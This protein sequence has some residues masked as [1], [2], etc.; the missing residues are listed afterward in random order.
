[1][2]PDIV[3]SYTAKTI[4]DWPEITLNSS[5]Q[6]KLSQATLSLGQ[7]NALLRLRPE[8]Q[9]LINTFKQ[10]EAVASALMD[11]IHLSLQEL[12]CHQMEGHINAHT[13][14]ALEVLCTVDAMT[15][16]LRHIE[17]DK[18][19][20][21]ELIFLLHEELMSSGWGIHKHPGEFRI[22]TILSST[23][24]KEIVALRSPEPENIEQEWEKIKLIL[25]SD[26]HPLIKAGKLLATLEWLQPFQEGNGRIAR[27]MATLTLYESNFLTAPLLLLNSYFKKHQVR[28]FQHL[29]KARNENEF[30]EWILFFL[31]AIEVSAIQSLEIS[32]R[33]L[34]LKD[35]VK[36]DI[37][38]IGRLSFSAKDALESFWKFPISNIETIV[39][40]ANITHATSGKVVDRLEK[41]DV[42]LLREITGQKRNR[43]F[44]YKPFYEILNSEL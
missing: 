15:L 16:G 32:A 22:E 1:M 28:Y 40:D 10:K 13:D 6:N 39:S 2:H 21:D 4:P 25:A 14:D 37:E 36:I 17:R 23:H 18:A 27:L 34:Q 24:A 3:P 30:E 41:K 44:L 42:D 19:F 33:L 12:M 8:A 5:L 31:S 11:G 9:S 43:V 29:N 7:L 35:T 26:E 38:K 20:N